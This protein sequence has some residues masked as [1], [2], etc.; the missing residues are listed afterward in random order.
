M[1]QYEIEDIGRYEQELLDWMRSS[2]S[3]ILDEIRSS[4]KFDDATETDSMARA[5]AAG[6]DAVTIIPKDDELRANWA[7]QPPALVW[8]V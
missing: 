2:R 3:E 7:R 4:G 1:R 6:G 8:L 5:V